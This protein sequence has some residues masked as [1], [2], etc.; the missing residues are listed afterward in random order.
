MLVVAVRLHA[1]RV[2]FVPATTMLFVLDLA[3]DN[4]QTESR[5]LSSSLHYPK[6]VCGAGIA[7]PRKVAILPCYVIVRNEKVR[8]SCLPVALCS[9]KL[10]TGLGKLNCGHAR[11]HTHIFTGQ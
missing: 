2:H 3:G 4:N 6:K 8:I 9:R 5:I 10:V 1:S 7:P 11:T